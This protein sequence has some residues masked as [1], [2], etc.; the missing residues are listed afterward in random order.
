LQV[1]TL[2]AYFIDGIAFATES[3]A[4]RYYGSGDRTHLR[5]LLRVGGG[6]SLA[7]GLSF[8][9]AFALF[10]KSLFGVLTNH[11]DV[12]ATVQIY[13]GW[14]FPVLGLGAMAYMLDGYF[15]GL[16]AGRVL[17]NGTVLAAVVGFLPLALVAQNLASAHL[18]WLALTGLMA[19]R[20]LT[21][22]WAVPSSLG[23]PS[24]GLS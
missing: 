10:P 21:L 20:A 14:L 11:S 23:L 6:T 17:R 12:I 15:L 3:F 2:S 18:L 1:V 22:G 16:T 4:G 24:G 9:L 7:L 5:R 13:V 19:A 8:A